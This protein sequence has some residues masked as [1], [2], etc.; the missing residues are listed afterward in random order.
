MQEAHINLK[1]LKGANMLD[2]DFNFDRYDF[3]KLKLKELGAVTDW[4]ALAEVLIEAD[5]FF[6]IGYKW[7]RVNTLANKLKG[8]KVDFK[9]LKSFITEKAKNFS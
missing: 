3:K 7:K 9:E 1:Y 6:C 2:I 8:A 5:T 4:E